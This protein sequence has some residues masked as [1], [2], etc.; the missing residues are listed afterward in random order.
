MSTR[1]SRKDWDD[2]S[3]KMQ[4]KK[5]NR[6]PPAGG[7]REA[8]VGKSKRENGEKNVM[9]GEIIYHW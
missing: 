9:I 6:Q 4:K 3:M 2:K 8:G 7:R 1:E 5:E